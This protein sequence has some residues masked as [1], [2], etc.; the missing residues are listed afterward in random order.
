MIDLRLARIGF[1]A[2]VLILPSGML[3]TAQDEPAPAPAPS[4]RLRE[5]TRQNK[6]PTPTDAPGGKP[7][8]KQ[9]TTPP[10]A[11]T[12]P[13]PTEALPAEHRPVDPKWLDRIHKDDRAALDE[14]VG[15]APPSFPTD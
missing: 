3:A 13:E 2:G 5:K 7:A 1:M 12:Q 4:N 10:E 15:Y 9:P 8:D 6:P 14:V 11:P